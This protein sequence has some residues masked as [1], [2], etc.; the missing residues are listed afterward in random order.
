MNLYKETAR[1]CTI[2]VHHQSI[3][4]SDTTYRLSHITH[5]QS[6]ALPA[7]YT[8]LSQRCYN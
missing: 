1:G 2:H 3:S 4:T 7:A 6:S 8:V 5:V